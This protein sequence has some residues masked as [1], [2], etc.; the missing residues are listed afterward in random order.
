MST[1]KGKL[2]KED[3]NSSVDRKQH[4][5]IVGHETGK[6]TLCPWHDG[7]NRRKRPR[8]DKYKNKRN[9]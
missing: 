6:C 2:D 8:A 1:G 5:R 9:K 3:T 7:E 4:K